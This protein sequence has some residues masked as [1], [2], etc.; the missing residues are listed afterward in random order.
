MKPLTRPSDPPGRPPVRAINGRGLRPRKQCLGL[1]AGTSGR[2]HLS[3]CAREV[4]GKALDKI[5]HIAA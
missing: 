1:F 3:H 2:G 4:G 5:V